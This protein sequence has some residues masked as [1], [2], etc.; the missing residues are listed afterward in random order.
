MDF[1]LTRLVPWSLVLECFC[2]YCFSLLEQEHTMKDHWGELGVLV[3]PAQSTKSWVQI[4]AE[5]QREVGV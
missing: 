4:G 1:L 5:A 2:C 3:E